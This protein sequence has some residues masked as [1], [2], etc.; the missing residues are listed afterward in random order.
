MQNDQVI[1]HFRY[2]LSIS[3]YAIRLPKQILPTN[4]ANNAGVAIAVISI[5]KHYFRNNLYK[6]DNDGPKANKNRRFTLN[7]DM[8]SDRK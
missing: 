3:L 5:K 6:I 7:Y 8:M 4:D 2:P 1:C